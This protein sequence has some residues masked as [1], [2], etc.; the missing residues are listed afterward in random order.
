[1]VDQTPVAD[2]AA[3]ESR[4]EQ[5]AVQKPQ[6]Q[7]QIRADGHVRYEKVG[8]IIAACQQSGISHIDFI[9]EQPKEH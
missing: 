7:I 3:L 2:M 1:M 9:T 8:G 5:A 6:P 4:L